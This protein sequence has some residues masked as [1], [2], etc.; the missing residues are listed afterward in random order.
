[1]ARFRFQKLSTQ[2]FGYFCILYA[3]SPLF[4]LISHKIS[5]H[6][7]HSQ[8]PH[9]LSTLA[10]NH[11]YHTLERDRDPCGVE[12]ALSTEKQLVTPSLAT[13][14]QNGQV[15]GDISQEETG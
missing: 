9:T 4:P 5:L 12:A 8:T 11:F 14:C 3:Q 1:M 15:E 10:Q 7:H 6:V 13:D 2:K